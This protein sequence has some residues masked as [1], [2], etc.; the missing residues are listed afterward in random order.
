MPHCVSHSFSP[1]RSFRLALRRL[2][3]N[4]RPTAGPTRTAASSSLRAPRRRG[5]TASTPCLAKSSTGCSRCA[6]S[7]TCRPGKT[8]GRNST[9]SSRSAANC[10]N[11]LDGRCRLEDSLASASHCP[12]LSASARKQTAWIK[13]MQKLTQKT[14]YSVYKS[15]TILKKGLYTP[16]R[17]ADEARMAQI[18]RYSHAES[19]R[20]KDAKSRRF[21]HPLVRPPSTASG[22]RAACA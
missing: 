15:T 2:K 1:L 11:K 8:I 18:T 16:K 12:E 21:T 14:I 3:P 4:T 13:R 9:W 10:K 7:R 20:I 6:R 22:W 19:G 5:W 17:E